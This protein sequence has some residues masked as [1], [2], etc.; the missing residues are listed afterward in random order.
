MKFGARVF[1]LCGIYGLGLSALFVLES[2]LGEWFPP[3]VN[4]P[5]F[6][7]GFTGTVVAL[8]LLFF[9]VAKDPARY[10]ALMPLF[11]LEKALFGGAMIWLHLAGRIG[12]FPWVYGGLCDLGWGVLFLISYL[13]IGTRA[14]EYGTANA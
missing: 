6:Y 5:E 13:K 2:K 7:Y 4:H 14:P 1:F 8:H 11:V 12:L 10:R 3:A 9:V